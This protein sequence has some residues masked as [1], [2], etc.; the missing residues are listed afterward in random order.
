MVSKNLK[1]EFEKKSFEEFET[2]INESIT[3]SIEK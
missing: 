1:K 3:S 2:S